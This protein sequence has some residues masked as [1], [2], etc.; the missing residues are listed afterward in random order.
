MSKRGHDSRVNNVVSTS[1]SLR[2]SEIWSSSI[3]YDPHANKETEDEKRQRLEVEEMRR[4]QGEGL[5]ELARSQNIAER[6]SRGEGEKGRDDFAKNM[7]WGLKGKKRQRDG[8]ER[9]SKGLDAKIQKVADAEFIGEED[10]ELEELILLEQQKLLE[11]SGVVN[12]RSAGSK[13]SQ[14]SKEKKKSKKKKERKKSKKEK[15]RKKK[16]KKRHSSSSDSSS[17]SSHSSS[18]SSS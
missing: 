4:K 13:K 6:E 7:F 8:S 5:M 15:K 17:S 18:S 3:G 12:G 14:K 16:K 9:V 11:S 2:T 1:N 10:T